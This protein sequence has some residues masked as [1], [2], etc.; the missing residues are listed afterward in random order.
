MSKKADDNGSDNYSNYEDDFADDNQPSNSQVNSQKAHAQSR[1]DL[2]EDSSGSAQLNYE[3]AEDRAEAR[4][5]KQVEANEKL[6]KDK[7]EKEK[8]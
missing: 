5:K 2:I 6:L 3:N 4:R 8:L 7:A 1:N